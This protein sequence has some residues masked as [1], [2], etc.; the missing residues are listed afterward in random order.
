M[1]INT[2][3]YSCIGRVLALIELRS[4]LSRIALNFDLA[5]APG[6][7]GEAFDKGAQDT[8]T[9]SVQGLQVVFTKRG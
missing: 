4:V 8:F 3:S 5:F 2:G 6:E 1:A 9:L 7:T